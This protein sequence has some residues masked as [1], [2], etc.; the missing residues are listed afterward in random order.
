[1]NLFEPENGFEKITTFK[2]GSKLS[3]DKLAL[4]QQTLTSLFKTVTCMATLEFDHL[5]MYSLCW[6]PKTI[7]VQTV[8]F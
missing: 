4:E 6:V 7:D 3:M 8:V 2:I 5:H 1:M